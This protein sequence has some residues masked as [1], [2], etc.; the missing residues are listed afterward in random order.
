MTASATQV[1]RR[2]HDARATAIALVLGAATILAVLIA[3]G[4]LVTK[5]LEHHWPFSAEDGVNRT[6]RSIG[7]TR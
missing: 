2:S 1:A 6:S 3:L 5:P 4:W 7:T